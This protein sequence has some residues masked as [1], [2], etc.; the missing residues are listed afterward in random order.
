[1]CVGFYASWGTG[2]SFAMN[3]TEDCTKMMHI[4]SLI[5]AHATDNEKDR[6]RAK[7][8]EK[9]LKV[10]NVS[11]FCPPPPPTYSFAAH[12]AYTH[13]PLRPSSQLLY[14][15]G[16]SDELNDIFMWAQ[17]S[18]RFISQMITVNMLGS[19][20]GLFSQTPTS[21][22]PLLHSSSAPNAVSYVAPS[23]SPSV[24]NTCAACGGSGA[25]HSDGS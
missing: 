18:Y 6:E 9:R 19:I 21:P 3:K 10:H 8:A 24:A 25:Q 23:A 11:S 16:R 14:D 12:G 5:D 13:Q 2:K 22:T 4:A 1:M 7:T 17:V 15:D 20:L